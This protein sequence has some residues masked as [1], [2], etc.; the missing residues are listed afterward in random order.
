LVVNNGVANSD[1]A[2]V[3]IT[4]TATI[5]P[6]VANAGS[7][8]T[9]SAGTL[10]TLN[11]S[12]SS[13]PNVPPLPL[14]FLWTQTAGPAVTLT[15]ANTPTPSFTPTQA[16]AYMFSL[17]VNNGVA[18]SAAASVTITVTATIQPPVAN[19]GANQTVSTGTL[20]TLNGSSSSDPNVPPLP[21]TFLWTQTAGPAVTLTGA[22]TA[23]PTFTPTQ[24][25]A[26]MFSLVV[27]NGVANSA[28][29]IVTI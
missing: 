3:T 4:E 6:P 22:N 5:Q 29:A 20:V 16:G 18:N 27:N 15:G 25:G 8:Q 23:K 1:A 19:A 24:A 28:A 10:V 11:G 21:L 13:D 12:G 14:T 2:S 9:V 7:N 17:V 26:Y